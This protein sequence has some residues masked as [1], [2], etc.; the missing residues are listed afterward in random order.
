MSWIHYSAPMATSIK[1][2]LLKES[3]IARV[4]FLVHRPYILVMSFNY[5]C[6]Y[7]EC[8]CSITGTL[9]NSNNCDK[10]TGE[11]NIDPG[12]GRQFAG[13]HCHNCNHKKGY[14]GDYPNCV[15]E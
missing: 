5:I 13:I 1:T 2:I 11:C 7:L 15:G 6:L 14:D 10:I 8:N 12:C 9:G 4:S 3:L